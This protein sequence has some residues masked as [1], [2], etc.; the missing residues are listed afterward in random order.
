MQDLGIVQNLKELSSP[1]ASDC[2][3]S[4]QHS[5]P[6]RSP[7]FIYKHKVALYG[8]KSCF[9]LYGEL[10]HQLKIQMSSLHL[11][12]YVQLNS[13]LV[14]CHCLVSLFLLFVFNYTLGIILKFCVGLLPAS[15]QD[16]SHKLFL[17]RK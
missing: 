10:T 7:C 4:S 5:E 8:L 6:L 12:E 14:A 16:H 13:Y 17:A 9:C 3:I 2:L 1:S 15:L 11:L